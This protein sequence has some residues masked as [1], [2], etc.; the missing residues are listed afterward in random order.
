MIILGSLETYL[1]ISV[2][3]NIF[4]HYL[5][6]LIVLEN[7]SMANMSRMILNS[8]NK[9]NISRFLSESKYNKEEINT[10]KIEYILIKTEK[11]I[12]YIP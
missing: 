10:R 9:T 1:K 8:G 7:K 2:S 11:Y 5:T 4:A 6:G 3:F 12:N